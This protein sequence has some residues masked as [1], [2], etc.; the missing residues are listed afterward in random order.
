MERADFMHLLHLSE[1]ASAEAPRAYRRSVAL[2]AAL[3][4]AW[5]LACVGVAAAL[6]WWLVWAA[7]HGGRL[8]AGYLWGFLGGISLLWAGLRALWLRL[9]PP[10]GARLAPEDAPRLFELLERIRRKV[11]GPPI[12]QVLLDDQFNAGIT[13]TPRFGLLGG[14]VN[15][16]VLGLPL[17]MALDTPRLAAVLAHEY[18]HLRGGHGR[19]AAWVYRSRLSWARLYESL[20]DS[21]NVASWATDRFLSWYFPR[22]CAKTFALARQDEYEADRIAA[23]LA[24]DGVAAATLVEIAIKSQWLEQQFWPGHWRAAGSQPLPAGP[25][26]AMRRLLAAPVEQGFAQTALRAELK[27]LSEVDDTHPGLRDRLQSL[28]TPAALPA[29]SS[30]P[31]LNLLA[32]RQ[33]WIDHFDKAW[34]RENASAWK[35]HHA[36]LARVRQRLAELQSRRTQASAGEWAEMGELAQRL[37]PTA[38]TA[39]LFEQALAQSP[40]HAGAL[41]GLLASLPPG[42]ERCLPLCEQLHAAGAQHRWWASR[43]AVQWLETRITQDPACEPELKRW[44]ARQKDA[45][46]VEERA[47]QELHETP[48]FQ[49]ISRHDLSEFELGELRAGLARAR[50]VRTAWLVCKQLRELPQRRAYVLFV[51]L[52]GLDDENSF[53][54]CRHLEQV[55]DLP[56]PVLALWAG[57]NPTLQD[58]RRQAFQPVYPAP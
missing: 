48:C 33:R 42:D 13:Q 35:Q 46:A 50:H 12:H 16:L 25:Y 18:G 37:D 6:L 58:I 43:C 56:G 9:E 23:R 57:E 47:W 32:D 22:F 38:S 10:E 7:M 55:L 11:K 17:L 53:G 31:A 26:G 44:R 28:N 51:E 49:S 3:G 5:V 4:Y 1:Q 8:H 21:D 30:Q 39:H 15:T 34:R 29:W 19:F 54:L 2:F 14:G 52:S 45:Q 27:R 24:G 40:G 41:R 36:Y 20:R